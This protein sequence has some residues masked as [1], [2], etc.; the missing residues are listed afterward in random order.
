MQII[1]FLA[2]NNEML[3]FPNFITK[4]YYKLILSN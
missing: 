1:K 4:S 3:K 2:N